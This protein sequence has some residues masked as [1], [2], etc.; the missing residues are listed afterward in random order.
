MNMRYN[1]PPKEK[2]HNSSDLLALTLVIALVLTIL[3]AGS[4]YMKLE[5][6]YNALLEQCAEPKVQL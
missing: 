5:R 6:K 2:P 1:Y 4:S 3:A